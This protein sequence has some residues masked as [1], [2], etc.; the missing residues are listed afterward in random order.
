MIQRFQ[1]TLINA[2]CFNQQFLQYTPVHTGAHLFCVRYPEH[3]AVS[4]TT[5]FM[6]SVVS[7][8]ISVYSYFHD[9]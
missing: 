3:A 9:H 6:C 1:K 7:I 8:E 2:E 5:G 4:G